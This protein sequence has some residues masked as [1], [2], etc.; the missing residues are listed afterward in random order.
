ML[1]KH[2]FF[3]C[4]FFILFVL[5][6][7]SCDEGIDQSDRNPQAQS[8]ALNSECASDERCVSGLC[9]LI[10]APLQSANCDGNRCECL[11]DR[12]CP[13]QSFCDTSSR[14]CVFIECQLNSDCDLGLVCIDHRCLVDLEA[15]QDR[16]G[17]PDQVDNCPTVINPN[18]TNTDAEWEGL[19]G[20][21]NFADE[22]GDA[23]DE[24]MDNDGVNNEQD[25]CLKVFNPDQRDG[26]EDGGGDRCE[27]ILLGVCGECPIDRIEGETLFCGGECSSDELCVPG[28]SR[29]NDNVRQEC[30]LNGTWDILQ[31]GGEE[32]CEEIGPFETRCVPRICV[33]NAMSC[34][35]AGTSI[36]R[37]DSLGRSWEVLESCEFGRRC[38]QTEGEFTCETEICIPNERRCSG[39]YLQRCNQGLEWINETCPSRFIC[40]FTN[41]EASCVQ[42][43]CGNGLLE[44]GEACDDG[45]QITEDCPYGERECNVCN[46]ICQVEAGD[47]RY[48]GDG[49]L[50]PSEDCDDGNTETEECAYGQESCQVCN[51]Q[52]EL[53][54]GI[55]HYCGDEVI[56]ET[57]D[58]DDG[59]LAD[60][61]CPYGVRCSVCN[62]RCELILGLTPYCGDGIVD[63]AEECDLGNLQ[64]DYCEY[65]QSQCQVCSANCTYK[66]GIIQS[67]GDGIID[68]AEEEC[69]DG[70]TLTEACEYNNLSPCFV[71]NAQ[72]QVVS[73]VIQS[74]GDQVI[75]S[76]L[77]QCDDGNR[78]AGDGCDENCL[79]E[80]C[81]NGVVQ[82]GL[83]EQCDDH[84]RISGDGC[85]AN[86]QLECG[87]G[88][89]SNL[90][91]CDDGNRVAG[92]GCNEFCQS[93]YCGNGLT[94]EINGEECDDGNL[95]S[96]DG[97][98]SQCRLEVC[99]N[100]IIQYGEECDDGNTEGN[101][102]CSP[103]CQI[104]CGD[105]VT[106]QVEECDDGNL[107]NGDGCS[108]TCQIERCGNGILEVFEACDDGNLLNED[109]CSQ[110]CLIETC[111]N[112]ILN[113]NFGEECDDANDIVGDGCS[114][115]LIEQCGNGRR[116]FNELCD[117]SEAGCNEQCQPRPCFA[118]GCPAVELIKVDGG[119]LKT[120]KPFGGLNPDGGFWASEVTPVR[121]FWLPS[122]ELMR[123]E[124][125]RGMYRVCVEAAVCEV[126]AQEWSDDLAL[127][128]LPVVGVT[129]AQAQN[130][131][132]WMGMR[133]P[134]TLEWEYAARSG[135]QFTAYP[136][137]ELPL[138]DE[139]GNCRANVAD[140]GYDGLLEPCSVA[141][142]L[143]NVGI[144]D[145]AGNANEWTGSLTLG[146][147]DHYLSNG[148]SRSPNATPVE[149]DY[150]LGPF[151]LP[152]YKRLDAQ[153]IAFNSLGYSSSTLGFRLARS[154]N[155]SNQDQSPWCGN[156]VLDAELGEACDDGDQVDNPCPVGTAQCQTC[157]RLCQWSNAFESRCGDRLI[158]QNTGEEC[159]DGNLV[160]GDGCDA[161]CKLE[162]CGDTQL[163][164]TFGE[165]CDD[166]NRTTEI[167]EY[168]LRSCLVCDALCQSTSGEVS[169]C[170]DGV[171]DASHGEACD[172][173]QDLV[174]ACPLG[175]SSCEVCNAQCQWEELS[176][177]VCGDGVIEGEESCEDGNTLN[178]DGCDENCVQ[179]YC[180]N[181]VL[182]TH[183]G[184]SCDDG[185][186]AAGDGCDA[187]CILEDGICGDGVVSPNEECDD[188]DLNGPA[189]Q[190]CYRQVCGNGIIQDGE[191]CDDGNRIAQDG[192]AP[193]C[194]IESCGDGI[195]QSRL[196][197]VCDDGNQ[198]I[199][200][201]CHLNCQ[202][203]CG[204]GL[205]ESNEQCDDGNR[206]NGDGCDSLCQAEQCGNGIRQWGE[207]CD[208]GNRDNNDGCDLR[209]QIEGC[210]DGIVQGEEECDDTNGNPHDGC[211]L[212]R[213]TYC[214]DALVRNDVSSD[215][216]LF[217]ECDD[218]D[219]Q[220]PSDGCH[221]C[222]RPACGDGILQYQSEWLDE[223]GEQQSYS[224]QCDGEGECNGS[225]VLTTPCSASH[226]CP[227]INWVY[228]EGGS[229]TVEQE[230][231]TVL[232]NVPSFEISQHEITVAQYRLC[233]EAGVCRSLS[234]NYIAHREQHPVNSLD[235]DTAFEYAKWVGAQLP[236]RAQWIY[237]ASSRG[238]DFELPQVDSLCELGDVSA[239][240]NSQSNNQSCRGRGSSPVC[241]T[242]KNL[243][244][245]G[246]CDMIGNV[247]EWLADDSENG[248]V[249]PMPLDGSPTCIREDCSEPY[250]HSRK[251]MADRG[252]NMMPQPVYTLGI[253]SYYSFHSVG[254]RLVRPVTD[255]TIRVT[256]HY[257]LPDY[258]VEAELP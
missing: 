227:T 21:P 156:G 188:A 84:N 109:G 67:C 50:D 20:G 76:G 165:S 200:D 62:D 190:Y 221:Q 204:N 28:R 251:A 206:I 161:H 205:I 248:P 1:T 91:E 222:R 130:F 182:Q 228:I 92:D 135:G 85:D 175:E 44:V 247:T 231:A 150:Y 3:S 70:N 173:G 180:A 54:A 104:D 209:C 55:T 197:E 15:D 61:P 19:P 153:R 22:L 254:I 214:G 174:D 255:W 82:E 198:E 46:A 245:Q 134:S 30:S 217:E 155:L 252:F 31:C 4:P 25:N 64:S 78:L 157:N 253:S 49:L 242:P 131:A 215:D 107:L 202:F 159:D 132:E 29:C 116:E 140:C 230:G 60:L 187:F 8:C 69:D 63:E 127:D 11:S 154:L 23:C 199:N 196:G 86:C 141:G 26:D 147:Y 170:G 2:S 249:L 160:D 137:G 213:L 167:C 151:R 166:G 207:G 171:V 95:I 59:G 181:G 115:C 57:E 193:N 99:G 238:Q 164:L 114:Q 201:G 113:S 138:H 172:V 88:F 71:C 106:N 24:D 184:E 163:D 152:I 90:E 40:G 186:R 234:G 33:P 142:D 6:C 149:F 125:T 36:D 93:E 32:N 48:C 13:E 45:N 236:S 112:G 143:S 194:V 79:T 257:P 218:G 14:Y 237:A 223:N 240:N 119:Y 192:C 7:W 100:G 250:R 128:N 117:A 9:E 73:G 17:V 10:E 133:L 47:A 5:L 96:S 185:N 102:G 239:V 118:N 81:G 216:P 110:T 258:S 89:Q 53:E 16:D 77:E 105:G 145:L 243:T 195:V 98:D 83:G 65:G 177:V 94:E 208:D 121:E 87:D 229:F 235:W 56:D 43:S 191:E 211:H 246:L 233:V 224:E 111:G 52:C 39:Q 169:Y 139:E 68:E 12:D 18:Q 220:N 144:C 158:D 72:C 179:E 51:D 168:G 58:C 74:C 37:C 122:F 183:L 225:C 97:C 162:S 120:G 146:S 66:A 241:F 103:L 126:P 41:G 136:W 203:E 244:Q 129:W 123:T 226:S 210:G 124:V 212:C 256:R 38:A 189:C 232:I 42:T 27:P 101:D 219:D 178:F 148:Q 34:G 80:R 176:G 35:E 108:Q 75:Q